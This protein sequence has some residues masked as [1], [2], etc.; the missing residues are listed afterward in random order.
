MAPERVK[1]AV[2]GCGTM[3]RI[4]L[5]GAILSGCAQLVAVAD[6]VTELAQQAAK[7]FE[8]PAVY[9]DGASAIDDPP[10]QAV[11]LALPT[12]GRAKLALRALRAGKHVLIEKP[13][14]MNAAEIGE[15]IRASGTCIGA[16][17]SSRYRFTPVA[18]TAARAI[19]DGVLGEVRLVRAAILEPPGPV[20]QKPPP[21]WRVSRALNGGGILANWGSYDIDFLLGILDWRARPIVGFGAT[22][23]VAENM[24]RHVAK[25]SDAE[26]LAVGLIRFDDGSAMELTRGEFLPMA[27]ETAWQVIGTRGALRLQ[28]V[29]DAH[30]EVVLDTHQDS[31]RIISQILW[32]G[33]TPGM[34][35]HYGPISDF[36]RAIQTGA[37]PKT[38][39]RRA[40]IVQSIIDSI[41]QSALCGSSVPIPQPPPADS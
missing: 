30:G 8:V 1:L 31:G 27:P 20:P 9:N 33:Q 35:H 39:L 2:I 16:S 3:G 25:G 17:C 12:A 37:R 26:T 13:S 38:D 40:F 36:L 5:E 28:M 29:A 18:D 34:D 21:A 15:L 10:V 14:G 22:W 4:H 11:I 24:Q 6:S 19:A 23:G 32:S 7:R 41:Y